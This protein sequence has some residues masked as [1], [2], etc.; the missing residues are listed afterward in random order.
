MWERCLR[1]MEY[2]QLRPERL[3]QQVPLEEWRDGIS[4]MEKRQAVKVVL[5]MT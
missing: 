2:G 5:T 3:A 1:L 4:L